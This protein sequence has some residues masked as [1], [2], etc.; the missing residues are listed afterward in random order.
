MNT[1]IIAEKPSVALRIAIALGNSKHKRI[2]NGR[3]SYYS[4]ENNGESI[5][6]VSAVGHLFTIKQKGSSRE[7]PIL[8]IEWAPSY[9]ISKGSSFT[10]TYLDVIRSVALKCDKFINACD[11]DAE[12]TVIGTNIIKDI[13]NTNIKSVEEKA[14]RMKF[15]TT[16]IPELV[17]SFSNLMDMDIE[18]FYAGE[19]RHMIDWLWGINLSRALTS[20]L[21]EYG[22]KGYLSI[23]RVQG[24][25]L[26]VLVK[27][28]NNIL[29]FKPDSYWKITLLINNIEFTNNKGEIFEK[30]IADEAFN[31][32]ERNIEKIKMIKIGRN[33]IDKWPFPPF[34]L[35]SLQLEASRIFHI[36]PS[37]TLAV[38][39]KLYERAYISYPRT[40]SQKLPPTL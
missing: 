34:D 29:N 2:V 12:G 35:T 23:G 25:T 20:A 31:E 40:S 1:L 5:Y 18:N 17:N 22:Y 28:E 33:E 15:S 3:V 13:L 24:P 6:V 39:Q 4:L 11:F 27:R 16:T 26:A 36:D 19:T 32:T 30:K 8:D 10:K 9:Q 37:D 38:A 14:K 21:R 7:Y